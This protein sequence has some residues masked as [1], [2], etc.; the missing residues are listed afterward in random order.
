MGGSTEHDN[1][2][3]VPFVV[4]FYFN[5]RLLAIHHRHINIQDYQAGQIGQAGPVKVLQ[6]LFPVRGMG[7]GIGRVYLKNC[8]SYQFPV[9]GV[10]VYAENYSGHGLIYD[11]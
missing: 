8:I 7:Y 11:W 4:S 9:I 5:Q 10:I 2:H 3:L 1:G 6:G